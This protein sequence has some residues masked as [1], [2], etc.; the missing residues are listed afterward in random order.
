MGVRVVILEA[1]ARKADI[2]QEGKT[3]Q[4]P[5]FT[6]MGLKDSWISAPAPSPP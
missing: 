4:I 5:S 6:H 3:N 1:G 2:N